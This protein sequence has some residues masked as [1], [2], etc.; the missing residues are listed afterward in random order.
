M[1]GIVIFSFTCI[2]GR[3]PKVQRH[4]QVLYDIFTDDKSF[5][6]IL[7]YRLHIQLFFSDFIPCVSIHLN[8]F[9][10]GDDT[11]SI[12]SEYDNT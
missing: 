2:I 3:I 8:G 5:N 7:I 6:N 11:G 9:E 1:S 10:H 4:I 12:Q